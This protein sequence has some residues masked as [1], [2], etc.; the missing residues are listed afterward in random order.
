MKL[1]GVSFCF[2]ALAYGSLNMNKQPDM[3]VGSIIQ[4]RTHSM[5]LKLIILSS[6]PHEENSG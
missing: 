3:R 1:W 4:V 2:W 5:S 6:F